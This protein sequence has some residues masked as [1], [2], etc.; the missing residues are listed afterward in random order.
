MQ[1]GTQYE[2]QKWVCMHLRF[3]LND[4]VSPDCVR[5]EMAFCPFHSGT[6]DQ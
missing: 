5:N 1:Q 6:G 2:P 4:N 3:A